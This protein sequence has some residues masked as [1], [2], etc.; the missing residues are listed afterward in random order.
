MGADLRGSKG[1]KWQGKKEFDVRAR[2]KLV[3]GTFQFA[4]VWLNLGSFLHKII[5]CFPSEFTPA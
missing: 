1:L 2:G 5:Y 4:K 3:R